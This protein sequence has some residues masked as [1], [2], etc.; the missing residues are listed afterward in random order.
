[1]LLGGH[2]WTGVVVGVELR[3]CSCCQCGC[4]WGNNYARVVVAGEC[5]MC[6]V[7]CGGVVMK[8]LT[9]GGDDLRGC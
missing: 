4:G 1:M 2:G 3:A 6:V 5:V 7:P 9:L 8:V